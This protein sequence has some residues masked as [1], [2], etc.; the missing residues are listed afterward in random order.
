[1]MLRWATFWLTWALV[2]FPTVLFSANDVRL[3]SSA[4]VDNVIVLKSKRQLMLMKGDQMLKTYR[5]ALGADPVG[6]KSRQGD[7]KTPEG[8]YVLDRRNQKSQ[9]YRSIHISYPNAADRARATKLAVPPGGDIFVHGWPNG[10]KPSAKEE[11][12]GDWTDGCIAVTDLEM[13]EIWRVVPDGTPIEI[14]P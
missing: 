8:L 4:V 12:L 9:F 7:H 5:I 10:Y 2:Q 11:D 13:D 3:Q 14:R 6:P 1:M